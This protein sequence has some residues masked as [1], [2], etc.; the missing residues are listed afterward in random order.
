MQTVIWRK[1]CDRCG[2]TEEARIGDTKGIQKRSIEVNGK[3]FVTDLCPN[4]WLECHH[5]LNNITVLF[6]FKE[7]VIND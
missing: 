6:N 2:L 4:C 3:K 1:T 5:R 7:E